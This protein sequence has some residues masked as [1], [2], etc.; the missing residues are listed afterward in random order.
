MGKRKLTA[1]KVVNTYAVEDL[2]RIFKEFGELR[3]AK[4]VVQRIEKAR[5]EK[6]I[7][8]VEEL[9]SLLKI[10]IINFWLAL[11]AKWILF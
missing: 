10:P 8:T 3:V 4:Q 11:A 9:K 7:T 1:A 2:E 6:K 5:A